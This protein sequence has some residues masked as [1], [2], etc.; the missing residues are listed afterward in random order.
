MTECVVVM[1]GS[2]VVTPLSMHGHT[3]IHR[4]VSNR[5]NCKS[6]EFA[7]LAGFQFV[8]SRVDTSKRLQEITQRLAFTTGQI[9]NPVADHT[10]NELPSLASYPATSSVAS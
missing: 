3:A 2:M 10:R 7:S 8:A 1:P 6:P 9:F 4:R 5:E